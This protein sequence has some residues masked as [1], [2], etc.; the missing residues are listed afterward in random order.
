MRLLLVLA[1]APLLAGCFDLHCGPHAPEATWRQDVWWEALSARADGS[2]LERTTP[3]PGLPW[4][5]SP[6]RPDLGDAELRSVRWTPER[7]SRTD[8]SPDGA[9]TLL[10]PGV[11]S[12]VRPLHEPVAELRDEFWAFAGNVTRASDEERE[13]A[14]GAFHASR[15]EV[16]VQYDR[17]DTRHIGYAHELSVAALL[18]LDGLVERTLSSANASSDDRAPGLRGVRADGWWIDLGFPT[19]RLRGHLGSEPFEP[20]VGANGAIELRVPDRLVRNESAAQSWIHE[21][22]AAHALPTPVF[23]DWHYS[24]RI[25]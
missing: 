25:C 5:R 9:W 21:G 22:A 14:W 24:R 12:T 19:V 18:D 2:V 11:L 23:Q 15:T 20:L 8:G 3:A 4:H 16:R 6:Q 7:P 13:E 1:A 17:D 10:P